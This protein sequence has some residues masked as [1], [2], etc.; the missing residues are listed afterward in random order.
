MLFPT[1]V[2][3]MNLNENNRM[4]IQPILTKAVCP[5]AMTTSFSRICSTAA[6]SERINAINVGELLCGRWTKG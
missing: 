2:G 4:N 5:Y 3:P 6:S 1:P